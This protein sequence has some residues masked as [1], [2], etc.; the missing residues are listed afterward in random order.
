MNTTEDTVFESDTYAGPIRREQPILDRL[1]EVEYSLEKLSDKID[2]LSD[3]LEPVRNNE[4][5]YGLVEQQDLRDL[6][7]IE[8][9]LAKMQEFIDNEMVDLEYIIKTLRV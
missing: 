8:I 1:D 5:V 7:P 4:E 3:R 9:R 2:A 6:S